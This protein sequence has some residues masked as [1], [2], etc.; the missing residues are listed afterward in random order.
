MKK[1]ILIVEY[2]SNDKNIPPFC[3]HPPPVCHVGI[4]VSAMLS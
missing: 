3:Y 1:K 2:S 4:G